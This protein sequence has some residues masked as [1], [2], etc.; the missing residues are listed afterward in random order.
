[1]ADTA[2]L[3]T[4]V[5]DLQNQVVDLTSKLTNAMKTIADLA[6]VNVNF[7]NE[8]VHLK[9]VINRQAT[10]LSNLDSEVDELGQYGRRE[11]IV[12]TNLYVDADHDVPSQVGKLCD[13]IG[14]SVEPGDFVD[15]HVLPS[16][17]DKPKRYI[18]RFKNRSKAKEIF[19]NRRKTKGISGDIKTN[20][21]NNKDRGFGILP[22]LTRKRG[23]FFNQVKT[24]S[25][26]HGHECWVDVNTGKILLKVCGA[27]RGTVIN[28]SSDLI[29]I[30]ESYIP[31]EWFF[32]APPNFV[33]HVD[34]IT[35]PA[36]AINNAS[37]FSPVKPSF[38]RASTLNVNYDPYVELAKQERGRSRDNQR[39]NYRGSRG[40]N[41]YNSYSS[42]ARGGYYP[43]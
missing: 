24:F 1:M 22:N 31:S 14:V 27:S 17:P 39:S 35:P 20:L 13:A 29:N 38:S 12:F 32:C 41:Y 9:T 15:A 26:E 11:N 7:Q 25:D 37:I 16:G 10:Y 28:N 34:N 43:Y 40:G 4:A 3:T 30:S 2:T 21:A 19:A 33:N 8:L 5:K 42:A 36:V 23:K 18:A 6:S